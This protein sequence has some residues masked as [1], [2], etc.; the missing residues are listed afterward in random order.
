V[1][2]AKS[3][4][5]SRTHLIRISAAVLAPG[6]MCKGMQANTISHLARKHPQSHCINKT[7]SHGSQTKQSSGDSS[8]VRYHRWKDRILEHED[9]IVR[10][11]TCFISLYSFM[12]IAP[13]YDVTG[14]AS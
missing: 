9:F 4:H 6:P 11:M 2:P 14:C 3:L 12:G 13:S 5:T 8:D 10:T 7:I 1:R